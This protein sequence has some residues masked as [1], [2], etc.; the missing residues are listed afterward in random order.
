M[1]EYLDLST[2]P[3]MKALR[4]KVDAQGEQTHLRPNGI[5]YRDRV[6]KEGTAEIRDVV[7]LPYIIR[8]AYTNFV[9]GQTDLMV[10]KETMLKSGFGYPMAKKTP[11]KEEVDKWQEIP[12]SNS[13][14]AKTIMV[15]HFLRVMTWLEFG[16][17]K[18]AFSGTE[19]I[20]REWKRLWEMPDIEVKF[21]EEIGTPVITMY[22]EEGTFYILATGVGMG[23]LAFLA[24]VTAGK[25]EKRRKN[26]SAAARRAKTDYVQVCKAKELKA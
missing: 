16:L 23:F 19:L 10:S 3:I 24:E 1:D 11:F 21:S 4:K 22:H 26:K 5:T 7:A 13:L 12:L 8:S 17:D 14:V 18:K 9:S 2:D 20:I 15:L 25:V 6:L